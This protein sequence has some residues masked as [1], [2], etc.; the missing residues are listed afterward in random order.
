M[1]YNLIIEEPGKFR[2]YSYISVPSR[3]QGVAVYPGLVVP[4][5]LTV[6]LPQAPAVTYGIATMPPIPEYK[7]VAYAPYVGVPPTKAKRI[8]A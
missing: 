4:F 2:R 5:D 6:P 3:I 1:N 7:R 8:F